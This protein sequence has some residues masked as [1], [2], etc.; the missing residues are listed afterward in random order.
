MEL[1]ADMCEEAARES[2]LDL[3]CAAAGAAR[4]PARKR[5]R[6]GHREIKR[7]A[8]AQRAAA[9]SAADAWRMQCL[10]RQGWRRICQPADA[11]GGAHVDI[12]EP[13][14]R[15]EKEHQLAAMAV[16]PPQ[17]GY[18][19]KH[20]PERLV[21]L[22]ALRGSA[23]LG[24]L[25][26]AKDRIARICEA[27][28]NLRPPADMLMRTSEELLG[29]EEVRTGKTT[30]FRRFGERS[31]CAMIGLSLGNENVSHI[32]TSLAAHP[33]WH[34]RIAARYQERTVADNLKLSKK[35]RK[36]ARSRPKLR[37]LVQQLLTPPYLILRGAA[38]SMYIAAADSTKLNECH[39]WYAAEE[40]WTCLGHDSA[41]CPTRVCVSIGASLSPSVHAQGHLALRL[42]AKRC[43]LYWLPSR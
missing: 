4:A 8:P 22:F 41:Q 23:G 10:S 14:A 25:P 33:S 37:L 20:R 12:I 39:A 42:P 11:I 26:T 13:S 24:D 19:R 40:S 27:D 28:L 1:C 9:L 34:K 30:F 29:S 31:V 16:K 18:R 17:E 2:P 43:V 15:R 5:D 6:L 21:E 7:L 38:E 35:L 36:Q 3:A 32:W